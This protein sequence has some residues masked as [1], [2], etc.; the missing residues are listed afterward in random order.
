MVSSAR[1]GSVSAAMGAPAGREGRALSLVLG[2]DQDRPLFRSND[3]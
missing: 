1:R 2:E 3:E